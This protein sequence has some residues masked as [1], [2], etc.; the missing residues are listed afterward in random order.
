MKAKTKLLGILLLFF[1]SCNN[2]IPFNSEL[3]KKAGGENIM[4]DT[5]LNMN[6]NLMESKLLINKSAA[7]IKELIGSSSRLV[8]KEVDH[9]KYYLV[10][11]RYEGTDVDPAAMVYLKVIFNQDGK[12]SFVT[13]YTMK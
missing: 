6:K 9:V 4:L 5:R 2:N 8:I 7:E 3:W 1:L 10:Q 13:L 12:A 11:E